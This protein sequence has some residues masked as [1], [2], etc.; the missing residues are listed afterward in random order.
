MKK[1]ETRDGTR[2]VE[3]LKEDVKGLADGYDTVVLSTRKSNKGSTTYYAKKVDWGYA[4]LYLDGLHDL[5]VLEVKPDE[6]LYF[7]A[8]YITYD[9]PGKC[10]GHWT[11]SPISRTEKEAESYRKTLGSSKKKKVLKLEE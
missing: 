1:Y 8:F 3:I 4:Y 11:L 10:Q 2:T 5:D 7:W 9:T 6:N